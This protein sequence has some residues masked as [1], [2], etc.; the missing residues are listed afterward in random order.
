[1]FPLKDENPTEITPY[2]TVAIIVV[3][4]AV[5]MLVQH[6]GTG[7]GFLES[8][9]AYGAI[10]GEITG[11]L[12]PGTWVPLG[13]AQCRIDGTGSWSLLTSMFMHGSWMHIIGNMWFLWIFGGNVEDA[14]GPVRFVLFYLLCG[15][16]AAALQVAADPSS[17]IPMVGASGAIGGVMG[18]YVLLYP[19][20]HVHMLFILV[21]Y[22]TTFAVPAFLMLG[23]WFLVQ[24]LSGVATY[25]ND[26]G[27]V[28]FWAHIGGFVAGG[29]L[30][31]LFRDRKLLDMHPYHG[32]KQGPQPTRN[33]HRID[34]D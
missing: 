6:A 4:V 33:W 22:V 28:A 9:C 7:V 31:F 10:P 3:N 27:G 24:V 18:A 11:A 12:A 34:R 25:G 20:V 2:V 8:L 13:P 1:V 29:V 23:Y 5:W 15:V 19:R 17:Q 30:V 26:G 21:F 16:A 32:W 14:M